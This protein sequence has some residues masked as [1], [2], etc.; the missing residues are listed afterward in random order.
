VRGKSPTSTIDTFRLLDALRVNFSACVIDHDEM[1]TRCFKEA[2]ELLHPRILRGVFGLGDDTVRHTGTHR[3]LAL[4]Q[5]GD[6][7]RS[8]HV[9]VGREIAHGSSVSVRR[10]RKVLP[11]PAGICR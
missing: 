11:G 4:T 3:K 10:A 1:Q 5:V 9:T 7:T 6:G 8:A 2:R